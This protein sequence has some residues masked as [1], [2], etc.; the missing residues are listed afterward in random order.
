MSSRHSQT[1]RHEVDLLLAHE[2]LGAGEHRETLVDEPVGLHVCPACALPFVVPGAVREVVDTN[3]V[4]LDLS[5][6]NCDWTTSTVAADHE[7]T[8]LDQ[9]LDRSYA[10]LLWT[11]EVVWLAN[12]ESAITTFSAALEADAILPEDF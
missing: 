9:Q 4:R 7:L 8:G 3:R 11:L 10:D 1:T 6:A 12:E 2:L 5:C